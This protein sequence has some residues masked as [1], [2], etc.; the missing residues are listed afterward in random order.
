MNNIK[1]IVILSLLAAVFVSVTPISFLLAESV[2]RSIASPQAETDGSHNA[3]GRIL[4]PAPMMPKVGPSSGK[5][6]M[7]ASLKPRWRT[8]GLGPS[9]LSQDHTSAT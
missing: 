5:A 2:G 4:W 6:K 3:K 8:I 7:A 9:Q 1:V